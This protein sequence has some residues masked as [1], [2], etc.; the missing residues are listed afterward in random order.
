MVASL[1]ELR[2]NVGRIERELAE[3]RRGLDQL[4]AASE[5]QTKKDRLSGIR[6]VDKAS[7]KEWFDRWFQQMGITVQPMGAEKLQEM[8]LQEGVR[9]GDNL[10]SHGI[11][12]MRE[13]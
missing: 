6:W 1:E 7:W 8:M 11:I 10:L 3:V 5:P 9:P 13:E 12:A 2:E 4:V